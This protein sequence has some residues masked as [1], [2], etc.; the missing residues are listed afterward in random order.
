MNEDAVA[1]PAGLLSIYRMQ[2]CL[3]FPASVQWLV[4]ISL[5]P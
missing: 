5:S 2:G 1:L 3:L 4:E